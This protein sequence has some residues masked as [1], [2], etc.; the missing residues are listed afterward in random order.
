[1]TETTP[2]PAV[3]LTRERHGA[4]HWQVL[5]ILEVALLVIGLL[6]PLVLSMIGI[7]NAAFISSLIL[8]ASM[9]ADVTDHAARA[10]GRQ[11]Q[12]G[13]PERRARAGHQGPGLMVAVGPD[14]GGRR[15]LGP[16]AG[17]GHP[18]ALRG[19]G[20]QEQHWSGGGQCIGHRA[21]LAMRAGVATAA[22]SPSRGGARMRGDV[23]HP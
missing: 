10:T 23:P 12:V 4:R 21:Y 2:L 7:C 20:S 9:V 1:M 13:P 11:V 15:A 16:Q 19:G 22:P 17:H 5:P 14:R 18:D 3:A 6:L 8:T